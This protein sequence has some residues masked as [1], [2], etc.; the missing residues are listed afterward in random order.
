M[1]HFYLTWMVF[2]ALYCSSQSEPLEPI[3][4]NTDSGHRIRCDTYSQVY[5][6]NYVWA[7]HQ[8]SNYEILN[9][10]EILSPKLHSPQTDRYDWD[11]QIKPN[12]IHEG[13]KAIALFVYL[14]GGSIIREALADFNI[15]IINHKE[16]ILFNRTTS[17]SFSA[18]GGWGWR[19][20]CRRDDFF[21]HHL[22]QNDTLTLL[23]NLRWFSQPCN[24]VSHERNP[25]PTPI[26]ETTTIRLNHSGHFESSQENPKVTDVRV[27][28]RNNSNLQS[29]LQLETL[30]HSD[31]VFTTNGS[32]YPAHKA[33]LAAR[34]QI[35]AAMF[36]RKDTKNGKNKTIRINVKQMNEEVLRAML[37]YIYTGKCENLAKLADELFVAASKYGLDDL[38]KI[39]EQRLCETLSAE[40]AEDMF[41]FAKKHHAN[42]LKFKAAQFIANKVQK[43]N[44]TG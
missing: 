1:D 30:K 8:F 42:E 39:C 41:V 12:Y 15:S 29:M 18:G 28:R 4:L 31:V 20:Y 3:Y 16:E 5:E 32:N 27:H 25:S 26:H 21:T 10:S 14:S 40:K 43:L 38:R 37:Q 44:A 33:I 11:I 6:I 9:A 36:Q 34:S 24:N 2:F 23:I 7:I 35:F 17:H 19:H 22:L 13:N